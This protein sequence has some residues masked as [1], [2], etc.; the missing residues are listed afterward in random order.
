MQEALQ[1][2][3]TRDEGLD[4]IRGLVAR[5]TLRPVERRFEVELEDEIANMAALPAG[6]QAC[7]HREPQFAVLV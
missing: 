4:L 6:G 2:P 7:R 3:T 5:V 1:D